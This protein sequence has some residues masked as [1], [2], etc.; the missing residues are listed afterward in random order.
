MRSKLAF[1]RDNLFFSFIFSF[2]SLRCLKCQKKTG[3]KPKK[4]SKFFRLKLKKFKWVFW[5][6]LKFKVRNSSG[7]HHKG[8]WGIMQWG[9]SLGLFK[10]Q[11]VKSLIWKKLHRVTRQCN[12]MLKTKIITDKKNMGNVIQSCKSFGTELKYDL[13]GAFNNKIIWF[14]PSI[15]YKPASSMIMVHPSF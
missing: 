6:L 2:L 5:L 4:S 14:E 9:L 10:I 13:L 7:N 11:E 15:I 3:I 8:D 1:S 12:Y